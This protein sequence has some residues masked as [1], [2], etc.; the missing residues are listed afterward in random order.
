MDGNYY[1]NYLKA[2]LTDTGDVRKDDVDFISARTD[3]A[4][5]EYE[6]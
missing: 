4:S 6:V 2:Y 1:S 5:E 3:A